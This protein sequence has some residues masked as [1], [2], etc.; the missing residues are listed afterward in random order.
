MTPREVAQE[1]L[2]WAA[3]ERIFGTYQIAPDYNHT[4]IAEAFSLVGLRAATSV[5]QDRR[6]KYVGVNEPN[7]E[8]VVFTEKALRAK[9]E[10]LLRESGTRNVKISFEMSGEAQ[11]GYPPNPPAGVPPF[12]KY[13]QFY[14]CGSSIY[15]ANFRGAGTLGCLV[16]DNAGIIFGLSNNHVV[17]GCN[18]AEIGVPISAPGIAD[19]AAGS[20]D[21]FVIGHLAGCVPLIAGVPS[22]IPTSQNMDVALVRIADTQLV[23]SMQR[24]YYDTPATAVDLEPNMEVEKVG[25]TTGRTLGKVRAHFP[26]PQAV[27]YEIDQIGSR[28]LVFF[29]DFY[30]IEP[31][32]A[33]DADAVFSRRGD[34]GSLVVSRE[35]DGSRKSVGL[36]FAGNQNLT[37]AFSLPKVLARLRAQIVSG[38][39]I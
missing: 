12:E 6:I 26:F 1:L 14:T 16:R 24:T 34:S 31:L 15:P 38:H 33:A 21:P 4:L 37:F 3:H 7:E 39:N 19:V 18:Y 36:I 11:A 35:P 5:L 20:L 23:S 13:N 32:N 22:V 10:K 29:E 9:D 17:S 28:A 27:T 30:A 2:K 25:R 8:V